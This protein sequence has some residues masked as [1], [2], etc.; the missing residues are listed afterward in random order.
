VKIVH[1]KYN[2]ALVDK[3]DTDLVAQ[4]KIEQNQE[5]VGELYIRYNHIV[6]GVCLKYVKNTDQ[7]ND[8]CLNVF[9]T[10]YESL[11]K[12]EINDFKS[13][14]L[15]VTRN[16]CIKFL[17]KET[18]EQ[19]FNN[20]VNFSDEDFME[21]DTENDHISSKENQLQAL[22][23]ANEQLKPEQKECIKLF[24]ID[25][26]SYQEITDLTHF[27]LKK[28]KS[29]IQNGKRNLQLIMEQLLKQE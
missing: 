5:M 22:E 20:E 16:S 3:S 8:I 6:Y 1:H 7:A 10:L 28:V 4:Y 21:S 15:T 26:K 25:D 13:W 29:Y 9:S 23:K 11:L 14:L 19:T 2:S 27:D 18:K 24:Y 12:Y 17:Q